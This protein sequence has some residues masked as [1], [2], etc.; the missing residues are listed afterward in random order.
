MRKK[1]LIYKLDIIKKIIFKILLRK[2]T[3]KTSNK[4]KKS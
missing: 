2:P 3:N 1:N 4:I